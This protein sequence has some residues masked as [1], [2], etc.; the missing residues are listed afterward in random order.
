MRPFGWFGGTTIFGNIHLSHVTLSLDSCS[1]SSPTQLLREG[2]EREKEKSTRSHWPFDFGR[3]WL[4]FGKKSQNTWIRGLFC[5]QNWSLVEK[6]KNKLISC[7]QGLATLQVE[8]TK[9]QGQLWMLCLFFLADIE[10]KRHLHNKSEYKCPTC[11]WIAIVPKQHA[12]WDKDQQQVNKK[13]EEQKI[14]N[15]TPSTTFNS[16][17]IQQVK[18]YLNH[19]VFLMEKLMNFTRNRDPRYWWSRRHLVL[20]LKG[21]RWIADCFLGEV[22][23]L[24]CAVCAPKKKPKP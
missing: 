2:V 5:T 8:A 24:T 18:H 4:F 1:K 23:L 7:I 3:R 22:R 10:A 15:H 14:T 19:H 6:E 16:D 17:I 12:K 20:G 9:L 11:I 21:F 13:L